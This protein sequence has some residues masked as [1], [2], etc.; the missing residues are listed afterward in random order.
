VPLQ[1]VRPAPN[2][3]DAEALAASA[4]VF[5]CLDLRIRYIPRTLQAI[6]AIRSLSEH[7]MIQILRK[8]GTA[9]SWFGG[10]FWLQQNGAA[11]SP[12]MTCADRSLSASRATAVAEPFSDHG[13]AQ[14]VKGMSAQLR[15]DAELLVR[16]RRNCL[17]TF[18][19]MTIFN[20][21]FFMGY[22]HAQ[23]HPMHV[24]ITVPVTRLDLMIPYQPQLL[25]AYVSLWIYLG[26]G[27]GLQRSFSEVAMYTLWMAA[28]CVT[29]LGIFYFWPT[30]V[31][32]LLPGAGAHSLPALLHRLDGAGNACPSMHVAAATFTLLRI[33]E[34]FRRPR[35]P[36][37]LRL[38][39]LAWFAVIA[40][41]TLAIKQ[42]MALDVAAGALLG[43][44]FVLASLRWRPKCA[45]FRTT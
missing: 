44:M 23:Q 7:V 18:A 29:A 1:S 45:S 38:I 35:S 36:L 24:P 20:A 27:P 26:A 37:L 11:K 3:R 2:H 28:L 22:F 14:T 41:S 33:D 6:A 40:Y 17:L 15:W 9:T 19:G 4:C 31:P 5:A 12:H 42:H 32:P 16:A 13:G 43:L 25:A 30:Q 39:N 34:V 8:V 10:P 21:L